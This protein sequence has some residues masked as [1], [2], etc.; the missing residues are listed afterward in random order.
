MNGVCG[1]GVTVGSEGTRCC[2]EK[3]KCAVESRNG[4]E[5]LPHSNTSSFGW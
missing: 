3:Q 4:V 1:R 2:R 5:A